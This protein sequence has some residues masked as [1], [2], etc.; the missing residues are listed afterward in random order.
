MAH[1]VTCC[2]ATICRPLAV[3]A[4]ATSLRYPPQA[5]ED[6]HRRGAKIPFSKMRRRVCQRPFRCRVHTKCG[7]LPSSWRLRQRCCRRPDV[8]AST[9]KRPPSFDVGAGVCFCVSSRATLVPRRTRCRLRCRF[10]NA[11]VSSDAQLI[12]FC[13]LRGVD[14]RQN[15]RCCA[16]IE[17]SFSRSR[18]VFGSDNSRKYA[19]ECERLAADCM[20]LAG[21]VHSPALRTHF[22]RMA[23]EWSSLA[24]QEPIVDIQT[25]RGYSD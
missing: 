10:H 19:L 12:F 17:H 9:P 2:P 6:E 14:H 11:V 16:R 23:R 24:V 18:A 8:G 15:T 7:N 25:E 20:Q 22:V 3:A 21:D 1:H 4:L 13:F 5:R